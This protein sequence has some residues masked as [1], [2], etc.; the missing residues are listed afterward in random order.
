LE[1]A[2][3]RAEEVNRYVPMPDRRKPLD[4]VHDTG[5]GVV[6]LRAERR[7]RNWIARNWGPQLGGSRVCKTMREANEYLEASFFE[8]FPEHRCTERC[9][10]NPL[11]GGTEQN[12][13]GG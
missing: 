6:Y 7:G 13:V 4:V 2:N 5:D 12:N 1:V 9:K 10:L 8:M 11:C 3:E